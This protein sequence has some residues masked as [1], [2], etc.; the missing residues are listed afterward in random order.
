MSNLTTIRTQSEEDE[1]KL[2]LSALAQALPRL[3]TNT[4]SREI[5]REMIRFLALLEERD[6]N[7]I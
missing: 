6:E 2:V 5:R 1:V 3:E 7:S 4:V